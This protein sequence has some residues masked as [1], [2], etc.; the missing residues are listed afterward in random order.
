SGRAAQ[1]APG[2]RKG[3]AELDRLVDRLSAR[4]GRRRVARL[5]ARDS[6]IPELAAASVPAQTTTRA[7]LGWGG[8]RRFRAAAS[9]SARPLRQLAKPE[10]IADIFA[11]VPPRPPPRL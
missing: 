2:A 7:D 9:L 8:F 4:L 1:L 5:L 11:P 6:H 10:P 3:Q